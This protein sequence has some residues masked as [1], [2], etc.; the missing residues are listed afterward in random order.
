MCFFLCVCV[1]LV[2]DFRFVYLHN[3]K[4]INE[5]N[6]HFLWKVKFQNHG[7]HVT[8]KCQGHHM[9]TNIEYRSISVPTNHTHTHTHTY[10]DWEKKL[11]AQL[12]TQTKMD[13]F[14]ILKSVFV[15]VCVFQRTRERKKNTNHSPVKWLKTSTYIQHQFIALK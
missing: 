10:L 3:K 11:L 13:K 15:C 7:K 6:F 4:K 12:K 5:R 8:W 1:C 14:G 2:V 9:R